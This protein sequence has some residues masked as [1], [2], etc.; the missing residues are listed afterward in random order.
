MVPFYSL[1]Q[2]ILDIDI[3][4]AHQVKFNSDLNPIVVFVK[5]PSYEELEARLRGRKTD[6]EESIKIRLANGVKEMEIAEKNENKLFD[7]VIMNDELQ[8]C[9][10]E[11][12]S[13]IQQ[14]VPNL[15]L[16]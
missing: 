13:V 6:S 2:C 14:H 8:R 1:W 16:D 3:Q 5:A 11:L 9:F 7:A 15:N 10:A 12:K 4:G